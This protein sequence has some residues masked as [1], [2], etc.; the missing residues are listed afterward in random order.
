MKDALRK[1]VV[2]EGRRILNSIE[3]G[4]CDLTEDEAMDMLSM[5]THRAVGK[6]KAQE[7][8]GMQKSSFDA[9]MTAGIIPRGRKRSS[10][11]KEHA[12]Y[13]DELRE[14]KRSLKH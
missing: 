14:V 9:Y 5:F 6:S 3:A 12:W 2:K 4:T 11:F 10:S 13:E 7:I 1:L 8:M